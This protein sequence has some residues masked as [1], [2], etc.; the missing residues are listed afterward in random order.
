MCKHKNQLNG[1]YPFFT[2]IFLVGKNQ[3]GTE[4]NDED[5]FDCVTVKGLI[6]TKP[7]F[8]LIFSVVWRFISTYHP[9]LLDLIQIV[10]LPFELS[11]KTLLDFHIR[12]RGNKFC[13]AKIS[14]N[15]KEAKKEGF[16]V[17]IKGLKWNIKETL[18]TSREV[19]ICLKSV[20]GWQSSMDAPF[21]YIPNGRSFL[22][23]CV[24]SFLPFTLKCLSFQYDYDSCVCLH[25]F[26]SLHYVMTL[27]I[28]LR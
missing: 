2:L 16:L 12:N 26:M 9:F 13:F 6:I 23:C 24:R 22:L 27:D 28:Y 1:F 4:K 14:L 21:S 18:W 17:E 3:G 20:E 8:I 25:V 11:A 7:I 10:F 19:L 15:V 5:D